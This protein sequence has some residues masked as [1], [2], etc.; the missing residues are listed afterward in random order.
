MNL[1]KNK[2]WFVNKPLRTKKA[3]NSNQSLMHLFQ[4]SLLLHICNHS[5][6]DDEEGTVLR[7]KGRTLRGRFKSNGCTCRGGV[8]CGWF[9]AFEGPRPRWLFGGG[10]GALDSNIKFGWC[11]S[12]ACTPKVCGDGK[13]MPHSLHGNSNFFMIKKN[14]NIFKCVFELRY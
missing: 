7:S 11:F 12:I 8:F 14:K 4:N 13:T 6:S 5:S 3:W 9:W 2:P 1:L 10:G